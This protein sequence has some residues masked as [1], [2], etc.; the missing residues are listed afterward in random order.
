MSGAKIAQ[1]P[2]SRMSVPKGIALGVQCLVRWGRTV[3]TEI[4]VP[5]GRFAIPPSGTFLAKPVE[6]LSQVIVR[7]AGDS[8]DGMQLTGAQFTSEAALLRNDISTL[9]H[10]PPEIR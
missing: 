6:Q 10:F 8:G 3:A 7:F 5:S 4:A 1:R 9:P 2:S